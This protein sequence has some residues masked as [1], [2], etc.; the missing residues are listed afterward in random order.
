[1]AYIKKLKAY[2]NPD[3]GVTAAVSTSPGGSPTLAGATATA[4]GWVATF[5]NLARHAVDDRKRVGSNL[6]S[7]SSPTLA[8]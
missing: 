1:M 2:N 4:V 3:L 6:N 5:T 8:M 7:T